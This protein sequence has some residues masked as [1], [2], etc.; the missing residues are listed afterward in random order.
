MAKILVVDDSASVRKQLRMDLELAG[1]VVLVAKDGKNGIEVL[2]QNQDVELIICDLNMPG[3][4]GFEMREIINNNTE[5]RKIPFVMLTT[6]FDSNS[7]ERGR[8][9]GVRAW[10]AKPYVRDAL[11]NGIERIFGR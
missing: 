4:D 2:E 5:W 1:H 8:A 11:L 6:E 7:K 9:L 10:I 3:V